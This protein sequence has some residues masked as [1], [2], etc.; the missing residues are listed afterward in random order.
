M[1]KNIIIGIVVIGLG[2]G[3]FI[4]LKNKNKKAEPISGSDD[5]IQSVVDSGPNI[6]L[7]NVT[8]ASNEGPTPKTNAVVSMPFN[9]Y[10]NKAMNIIKVYRMVGDKF[11]QQKINARPTTDVD[12]NPVHIERNVLIG[13]VG[14][15]TWVSTNGYFVSVPI[16]FKDGTSKYVWVSKNDTF[17]RN[18]II[19]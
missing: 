4:Y 3:T 13:L 7:S 19:K 12:S 2:I 6:P 1:N 9:V 15:K 14:N 11:V 18:V 10:A 8:V 17:I 5:Q 16:K